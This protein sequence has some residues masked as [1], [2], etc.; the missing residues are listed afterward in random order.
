MPWLATTVDPM[1]SHIATNRSPLD[2]SIVYQ[3]GQII[4]AETLTQKRDLSTV[5]MSKTRDTTNVLYKKFSKMCRHQ[6]WNLKT[7]NVY[8]LVPFSMY[9][10]CAVAR[11]DDLVQLSN[12]ISD[13]NWANKISASKKP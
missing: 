2:P 6:T 8:F 4:E 13:N 7:T 1:H 5:L 3:V 10:I 9:M 11:V 12:W